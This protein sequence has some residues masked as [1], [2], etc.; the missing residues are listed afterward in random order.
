[1]IL[2]PTRDFL[3]RVHLEG[4]KVISTLLPFE[5]KEHLIKLGVQVEVCDVTKDESVSR[6][7][8]NVDTATGGK[9]DMLINNAYV[10]LQPMLIRVVLRESRIV[11]SVKIPVNVM[12]HEIFG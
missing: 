11:A 4:F 9:L 6:L 3:L 8:D 2:V 10:S 5:S 1:M 7:R 12:V